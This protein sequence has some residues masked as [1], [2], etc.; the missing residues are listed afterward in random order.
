MLFLILWGCRTSTDFQ[1]DWISYHIDITENEI[2]KPLLLEEFGKKLKGHE[3]DD[4]S[5]IRNIRDPVYET[6][7]TVVEEA[8]RD[9]RQITGSL[10]WRWNMPLFQGKGRGE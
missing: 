9:H 4:A 7:Y 1:A 8:L 2:G 5:D 3:S 6:T 10:F